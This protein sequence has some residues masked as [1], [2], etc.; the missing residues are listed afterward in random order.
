LGM[1]SF[2]YVAF[3]EVFLQHSGGSDTTHAMLRRSKDRITASLHRPSGHSCFNL[4]LSGRHSTY[5]CMFWSTHLQLLPFI[6]RCS[7]GC[8]LH[9]TRSKGFSRLQKKSHI[10]EVLLVGRPLR[11]A[12]AEG[13]CWHRCY[14]SHSRLKQKFSCCAQSS[15]PNL[16][17]RCENSWKHT[18][19]HAGW[20]CKP[21]SLVTS[22][23]YAAGCK[24]VLCDKHCV[25]Q[26]RARLAAACLCQVQSCWLN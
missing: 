4:V 15:R 13:V 11:G 14:P 8:I 21:C 10:P 16:Q 1:I 5:C 23:R 17:R 9:R 12:A 3:S 22:F 2:L 26:A 7:A 18:A 6:Q 19:K 25:C 24:S 20:H